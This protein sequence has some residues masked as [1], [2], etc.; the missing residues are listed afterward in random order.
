MHAISGFYLAIIFML[1]HAV[2]EVHF[3]L[4]NEKGLV[5]ED[6]MIHQLQTSA[7]FSSTSRLTGFL[8]GGLNTQI[9]H[10][11]FANICSVHY[12]KLA[13]IVKQT[14]KEFGVPYFELKSFPAAIASHYRFLKN[15]GHNQ[16]Y[17]PI[18]P[19]IG[20]KDLALT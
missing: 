12:R 15:L 20:S 10:H 7:N 8:T 18:T 5:G 6:W 17:S 3:P 11:L 19:Q 16:E 9:E 1:A 4:P 2:E 13:P 14:C